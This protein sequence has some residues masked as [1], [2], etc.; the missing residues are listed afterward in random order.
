MP[1][2]SFLLGVGSILTEREVGHGKHRHCCLVTCGLLCLFS[3]VGH[4]GMLLSLWCTK[5]EW[6][7]GT[8]FAGGF[9]KNN[10]QPNNQREVSHVPL[11]LLATLKG[12]I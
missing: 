11:P 12:K 2:R 3:S 5:L 9:K 7:A 6:E 4:V 1:S 8:D 10:T